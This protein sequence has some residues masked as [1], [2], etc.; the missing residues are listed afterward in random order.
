MPLLN[1]K[2]RFVPHIRS[3][4]KRH[5]I[6]ANRKI[7]IKVGDNLYL[8]CGARTKN[9]F[10]ILEDAQPCTRVLPLRAFLKSPEDVE[11]AAITIDGEELSPDEL[12]ILAYHDGFDSWAEMR[13]FWTGR[14][15]FEGQIIHWR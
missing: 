14:Y 10:K 9:C 4:R 5:T 13:T 12:E 15:P 8:Y 7:P 2:K 6:R 11:T 3:G 1:F